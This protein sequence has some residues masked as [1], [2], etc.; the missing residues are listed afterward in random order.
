MKTLSLALL[1]LLASPAATSTSHHPLILLR[2]S[3]D[4]RGIDVQRPGD[5]VPRHVGILA[6]CGTPTVGDRHVRWLEQR[7]DIVLVGYGK[8]CVAS[9][10]M[11]DLTTVCS[12]CD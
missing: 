11:R 10:S 2:V 1:A 7:E 3:P 12:G 6:T 4:R 8:H 9:V 5:T